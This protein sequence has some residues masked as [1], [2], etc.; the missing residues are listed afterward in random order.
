[1]LAAVGLLIVFTLAL[2][3]LAGL[4]NIMGLVLIAIGLYEAWKVNKAAPF[5]VSGPYL[6]G[7][8]TPS[9]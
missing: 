4:D 1:M 5:K 3:F 2:P 6:V 9:T 7:A 8:K